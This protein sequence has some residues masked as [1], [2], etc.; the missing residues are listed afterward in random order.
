MKKVQDHYFQKAKQ[1]NYVARSAYKLEEINKKCP[2]LKKG[3]KVIDL[4]CCPGSWIQYASK[5]VGPTGKVVGV[6][7]NPVQIVLPENAVFL[8]GDINEID[9]N[10][11]GEHADQFDTVMS[12]MAPKTTGIKHL[13]ADRSFQLCEMALFVAQK[14]LKPN[15]SVVVKVFQ[16]AAQQ[17]LLEQMRREYEKVKIVKPKSSRDESVEVFVVGLNKKIQ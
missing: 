13:D 8:Q 14:W 1:D 7:L 4:G 3:N 15:G 17:K 10:F 12:D 16:G 9:L 2:I 11:A 6:D 5:V